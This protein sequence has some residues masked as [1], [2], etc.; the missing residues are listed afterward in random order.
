LSPIV[1]FY[2]VKYYPILMN[3]KQT[4]KIATVVAMTGALMLVAAFV[5][6]P[7]HAK[8]T[9]QTTCDGE[10]GECPGHSWD[11]GNGHEQDTENVNPNGTP[12][13]GQNKE[14]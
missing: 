11:R 5:N 12:P 7:A 10:P 4:L 6:A 14:D 8:I 2:F 3:S 9:E 1:F 13:P